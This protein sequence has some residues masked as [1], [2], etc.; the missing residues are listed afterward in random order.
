LAEAAGSLDAQVIVNIQGDE[1]FVNPQ[2][3]DALVTALV[4]DAEAS[5]STLMSRIRAEEELDDPATVKVVVDRQGRALYF[6]RS[7]I[8]FNRAPS[9]E[10]RSP[11]YKHLGLYAYHRDF[12]LLYASLPPT[13][14]QRAEQLEQL[15]AL[16]HGYRIRVV[17][18]PFESIG[19]DTER[20]LERA[21]ALMRQELERGGGA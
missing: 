7:R 21:R 3:L 6:S 9:D 17:E 5:M 20:D 16:E 14:L 12:L 10:D 19:V 18:T 13:S 2:M 15:R 8:P 1:P 11:V 4:E